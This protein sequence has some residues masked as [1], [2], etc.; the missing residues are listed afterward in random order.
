MSL[1]DGASQHANVLILTMT[2]YHFGF[3]PTLT[4]LWTTSRLRIML[5]ILSKRAE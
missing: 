2:M 5:Q 1:P 3:M 4:M